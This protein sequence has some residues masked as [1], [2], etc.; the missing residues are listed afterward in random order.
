[1]P[2]EFRAWSRSKPSGYKI[3]GLFE[4]PCGRRLHR[5]KAPGIAAR[6]RRAAVPEYRL[7]DIAG[8]AAGGPGSYYGKDNFGNAEDGARKLPWG[9]PTL[10][11]Y[12]GLS[13]HLT[14]A[15]TIDAKVAM[16]RAVRAK[17]PFYLYAAHYAVHAPFHS[18]PRFAD[19][20]KDSGKPAPARPAT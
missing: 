11:K 19:H 15:C 4:K 7:I 12:H 2:T 10:E 3:S 18:D 17:R 9:I 20:Y 14:D 5:S 16:T 1:M 6:I 13:I 8:H